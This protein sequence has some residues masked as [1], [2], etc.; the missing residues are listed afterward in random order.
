MTLW[1]SKEHADRFFASGGFASAL[2][3]V[4]SPEPAGGP[5][6]I[7]FDVTRSYVP[8]PSAEIARWGH[9]WCLLVIG[10]RS[11]PGRRA[12]PPANPSAGGGA[13]AAPP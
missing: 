10:V 1:E 7:G 3:K 2:A 9:G 4:L 8:S 11:T 12:L 13:G 6:V 5:E